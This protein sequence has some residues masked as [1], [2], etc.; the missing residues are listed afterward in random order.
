MDQE[1]L[2]PRLRSRTTG[3]LNDPGVQVSCE[4]LGGAKPPLNDLTAYTVD[5]GQFSEL[6]PMAIFDRFERD[7]RRIRDLQGEP[8]RVVAEG[9]AYVND[10]NWG[11]ADNI[12]NDILHLLF[13]AADD[14]L[15]IRC[16]VEVLREFHGRKWP[17]EDHPSCML[18]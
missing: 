2:L 7:D 8:H 5:P 6:L 12:I 18:K 9:S 1:G 15:R 14:H 3:I 16:Q 11:H 4:F 10:A 17:T 13:I